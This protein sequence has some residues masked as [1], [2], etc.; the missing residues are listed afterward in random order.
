MLKIKKPRWGRGWGDSSSPSKVWQELE[1][2]SSNFGRD[3][4]P[5][6]ER[7]GF[8]YAPESRSESRSAGKD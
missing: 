5:S 6:G 2:L 8:I 1:C 7:A 4:E 3:G